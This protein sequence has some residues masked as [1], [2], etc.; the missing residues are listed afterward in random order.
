MIQRKVVNRILK[1]YARTVCVYIYILIIKIT[2]LGTWSDYGPCEAD[3]NKPGQMFR[4]RDCDC[5][6]GIPSDHPECGCDTSSDCKSC[7]GPCPNPPEWNEWTPCDCETEPP[8]KTRTRDCDEDTCDSDTPLTETVDCDKDECALPTPKTCLGDWENWGVCDAVCGP[9]T[10]KR[11]RPC[12]CGQPGC[13]GCEG[14]TEEE[15][16]EGDSSLMCI[17][18]LS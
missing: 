6:V 1:E 8:V 14:T 18:G 3:C 9:G 11:D 5:P 4:E 7:M 10:R 16:C 2:L 13:P 15:E 17:P 12:F